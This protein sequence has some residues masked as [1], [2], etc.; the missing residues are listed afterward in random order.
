MSDPRPDIARGKRMITIK[1]SEHTRDIEAVV[2]GPFA[3]HPT[4]DRDGDTKYFTVTHVPTGLAVISSATSGRRAAAL[5]RELLKD[6]RWDVITEAD[7]GSDLHRHVSATAL[8]VL[9][10]FR[11][12]GRA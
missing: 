10:L 8:P 7:F 11:M 1:T 4:Q 6:S 12:R 9:R 3:Y 2:I 5:I